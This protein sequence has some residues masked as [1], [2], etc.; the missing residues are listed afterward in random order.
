MEIIKSNLLIDILYGA[1]SFPIRK[2]QRF[3]FIGQINA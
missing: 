3:G 1:F 2:Q